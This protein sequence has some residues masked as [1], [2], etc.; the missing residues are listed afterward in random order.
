M[1]TLVSRLP[2]LGRQELSVSRKADLPG[3]P[4]ANGKSG[5]SLTKPLHVSK[6]SSCSALSTGGIHISA[7]FL[8]LPLM[9]KLNCLVKS[10]KITVINT[11]SFADS[12]E[13][14]ILDTATWGRKNLKNIVGQRDADDH[15]SNM[16]NKQ[17][18]PQF[19]IHHLKTKFLN[20]LT[21]KPAVFP[22]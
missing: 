6:T 2:A 15:P 22:S 5:G 19:M 21:V 9:S 12:A 1:K 20:V 11:F 3:F 7:D 14:S 16:S 10:L 18:D 4:M 8:V 13:S 17:Q